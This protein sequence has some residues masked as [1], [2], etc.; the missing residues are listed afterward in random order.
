MRC[1]AGFGAR[2]EDVAPTMLYL[3]GA[4]IPTRSRRPRA[5][6]GHRPELLSTRPPS[7]HEAEEAAFEDAIHY[8]AEE[9]GVVEGRLRD[10]GYLE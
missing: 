7:Y 3:M 6:G 10:L 2:I 4:P 8:S 9:A 5:R 1:G